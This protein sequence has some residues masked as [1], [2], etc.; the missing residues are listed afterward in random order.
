MAAFGGVSFLLELP[1]EELLDKL[2]HNPY[3][4]IQVINPDASGDVDAPRGTAAFFW[5][6]EQDTMHSKNAVG[7]KMRP[8]EEW[9]VYRQS[10]REHSWTGVVCNLDLNL[11]AA[12]GLKT[13]EQTL[14][15][16]EVLFASFLDEVGFHAEPILCLAPQR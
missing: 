5:K 16:R 15:H 12:G 4:Y 11:C 9:I 8:G 3:S 14:A 7:C 6:C 13:H 1:K 10:N 2:K